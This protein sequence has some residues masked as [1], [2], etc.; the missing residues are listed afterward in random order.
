MAAIAYLTNK[1][2]KQRVKDKHGKNIKVVSKFISWKDKLTF[3][4][5][6][7]NHVWNVKPQ[8]VLNG[9]GCPECAKIRRAKSISL[10]H[11]NSVLREIKYA[12]RIADLEE[13]FNIE[14]IGT[15][16]ASKA[17]EF[18]FFCN[19]CLEKFSSP[20]R[21]MERSQCGCWKCGDKLRLEKSGSTENIELKRISAVLS[22]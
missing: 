10:A 20:L 15:L 16:P 21:S 5:T 22:T 14:Y 2:I 3:S 1:D 11:A 4:C 13:K 7:C 9:T 19:E 6:I 8:G 17:K 18:I 12:T